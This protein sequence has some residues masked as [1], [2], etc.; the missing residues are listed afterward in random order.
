MWFYRE[1]RFLDFFIFI[2]ENGLLWPL[3]IAFNIKYQ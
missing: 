2:G 3:I 1:N